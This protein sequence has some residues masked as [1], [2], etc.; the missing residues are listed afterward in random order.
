MESVSRMDLVDVSKDL[1]GLIVPRANQ[2][3]A[4]SMGLKSMVN[5][6]AMNLFL[7]SFVMR[8]QLKL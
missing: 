6:N 1:A 7:E 2:T 5:V 8:Q 4:I 3:L